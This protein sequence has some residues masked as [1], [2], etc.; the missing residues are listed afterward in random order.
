MGRYIVTSGQNIYDVA[1]HVYGSVE[2]I[3][4]LMM[5]NTSLSLANVLKAGDELEYTDDFII[6][7]GIVTY[8]KMNGIVPSN[9]E[10]NV[11]FK[12]PSFPKLAKILIDNKKNSVEFSL[13]GSGKMEIDWG[14]NS[15]LQAIT[16]SNEQQTFR[17]HFDNNVPGKRKIFIYGS[18][19][20]KQFDCSGFQAFSIILFQPVSVEKLTLQQARLEIDF[21]SLLTGIYDIDITGLRC[22]NLLPLLNCNQLMNLNLSGINITQEVLDEYLKNLV[23]QYYGRRN[24]CITL[25]MKPSGEYREPVRDG[26]L[27][28]ILSSGM[29]AV[30]ALVNEPAWNEGGYWKFIIEDT[31]YTSEP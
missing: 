16:L 19:Q 25:N 10:R 6:N 21:I 26:N 4:D 7:K 15:T 18:I 29:E 14:D 28:Y 9:G 1:L 12:H 5:N 17:H 8:Y 13:S 11:Y 24:C 27:N 2:G 30:W 23:K 20:V 3:V 22:N 31:I